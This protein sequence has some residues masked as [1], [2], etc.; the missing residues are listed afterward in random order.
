MV[1]QK[2]KNYQISKQ[3]DDIMEVRRLVVTRTKA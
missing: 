3:S 1:A 2:S